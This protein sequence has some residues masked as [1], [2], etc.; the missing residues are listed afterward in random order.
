MRAVDVQLEPEVVPFGDWR[1]HSIF[2]PEGAA[3]QSWDV[4]AASR[5]LLVQLRREAG[6]TTRIWAILRQFFDIELGMQS[7][8]DTATMHYGGGGDV[9]GISACVDSPTVQEAGAV[10]SDSEIGLRLAN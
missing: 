6:A 5:R 9:V 4:H 10:A 1:R 7:D 8:V 2:D 3:W